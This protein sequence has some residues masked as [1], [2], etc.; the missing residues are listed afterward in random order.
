MSTITERPNAIDL[1]KVD[2]FSS[3]SHAKK[4]RLRADSPLENDI[5]FEQNIALL[6]AARQPLTLTPGYSVPTP[7]TDDEIVIEI[8]A[9][10]LNPV[11]WKSM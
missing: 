4:K 9:I 7:K 1:S 11:D 8:R 6:Y 3:K 5:P 10:G 2:T